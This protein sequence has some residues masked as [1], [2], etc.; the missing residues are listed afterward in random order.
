MTNGLSKGNLIDRPARLFQLLRKSIL[1]FP[2][3]LSFASCENK[4]EEVKKE[5]HDQKFPA[6]TYRDYDAIYS[7]SAIVRLR[8]KGKKMEQY[9]DGIPHD[10]FE[11]GVHLWFYDLSGKTESE[12]ISN[13]AT[14]ER[15][16]NLMRAQGNVIVYNKKGDK[17]NTEQLIWD[18]NTHKIRTDQHVT[19]TTKDKIIYGNGLESDETFT[20]Y[21]V[22]GIRGTVYLKRSVLE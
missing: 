10:E 20:N 6:V 1:L 3:F 22:L 7:D 15:A 21:K 17:L 18:A 12:M 4:M 5:S 11:D 16:T 9:E 2:L 8:L 14:R 19:I 13:R